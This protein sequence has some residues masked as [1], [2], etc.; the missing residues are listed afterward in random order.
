MNLLFSVKKL[1]MVVCAVQ[2]KFFIVPNI[3]YSHKVGGQSLRIQSPTNRC[4]KDVFESFLV[5]KFPALLE[6]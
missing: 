3:Y 5:Y 6:N 4:D 1:E 2:A